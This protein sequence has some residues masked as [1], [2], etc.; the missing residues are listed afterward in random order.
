MIIVS[1]QVLQQGVQQLMQH[2]L[3][4]LLTR[5]VALWLLK[6]CITTLKRSISILKHLRR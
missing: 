3:K 6:L 1:W 4:L 5:H 2:P